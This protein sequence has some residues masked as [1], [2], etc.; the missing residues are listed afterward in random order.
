MENNKQYSTQY[1]GY[2]KFFWVQ[3][4]AQVLIYFSM[5]GYCLLK[6]GKN[7][8]RKNLMTIAV[9]STLLSIRFIIDTWAF[10][11]LTDYG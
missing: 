5:A 3:N 4:G 11:H 10:V 8:N 1:L 7:L 2:T 6:T 9:F